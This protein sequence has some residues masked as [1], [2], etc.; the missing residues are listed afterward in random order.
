MIG[1]EDV[2]DAVI[3]LNEVV[4]KTGNDSLTQLKDS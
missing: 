3:W 1:T 2:I 4:E